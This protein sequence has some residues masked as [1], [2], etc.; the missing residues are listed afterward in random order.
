MDFN[1]TH[2]ETAVMRNKKL[3][4]SLDP[5][6]DTSS[7]RRPGMA[8]D[9]DILQ[10]R[11]RLLNKTDRLLLNLIIEGHCTKA[12]LAGLLGISESSLSYRINRLTKILGRE[13]RQLFEQPQSATDEWKITRMACLNG[14]PLHTIA[15]QMGLSLYR[16]RK[17][18]AMRKRAVI[19]RPN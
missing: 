12:Q 19:K 15:R 18:T 2:K 6:M 9:R 7:D 14:R 1:K 10:V 11:S 5:D 13:F 4:S 3:F 16:V 17:I 8:I